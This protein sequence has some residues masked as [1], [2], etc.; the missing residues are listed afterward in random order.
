MKRGTCTL[1]KATEYAK[2]VMGYS[3][4]ECA[5]RCE[6][7]KSKGTC[8]STHE[9]CDYVA[10]NIPSYQVSS[11][12]GTALSGACKWLEDGDNTQ[13]IAPDWDIKL[14]WS[15]WG[16]G[17][18]KKINGTFLKKVFGQKP[19]YY[20]QA[21]GVPLQRTPSEA[22]DRTRKMCKEQCFSDPECTGFNEVNPLNDGSLN[23]EYYTCDLYTGHVNF[24]GDGKGW[25]IKRNYE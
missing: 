5:G 9:A 20:V 19:F 25:I 2:K 3:D 18:R 24:N 7:K 14:I 6:A 4:Y 16:G 23:S 17:S 21:N 8:E 13:E 22:A 15:L 1:N 10:D 12:S 11:R